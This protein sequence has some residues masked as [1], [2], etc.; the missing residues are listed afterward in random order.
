MPG[1]FRQQS[2]RAAR[3][4]RPMDWEFANV[5]VVGLNSGTKFGVYAVL[6]STFRDKY[7]DPTLMVSRWFLGFRIEVDQAAGTVGFIGVGL[8]KWDD[9]NDVAPAGGEAPG[10]ITDGRL[11]WINRY[12]Q[13][14]MAGSAAGSLF[15]GV[16]W[17][18]AHMSKAKRRMGSDG[19]LLLAFEASATTGAVD[20]AT[21]VRCLIKE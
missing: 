5:S 10:P 6:P 15:S 2:R 18:N 20:V 13:P 4:L 17:D 3:P 11:D 14:V 12:V 9:I 21:D 19:G 7:T 1:N 16:L 8:I